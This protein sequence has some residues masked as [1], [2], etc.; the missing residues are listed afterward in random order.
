MSRSTASSG[1]EMASSLLHCAT[2]DSYA[3][4]IRFCRASRPATV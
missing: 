2:S 3:L 4:G 1:A